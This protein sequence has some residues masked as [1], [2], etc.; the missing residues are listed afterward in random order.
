MRSSLIAAAVAFLF[1]PNW[2]AAE[3]AGASANGFTVRLTLNIQASPDDFYRKFVRNLG[4]CWDADHT[5]S[6]RA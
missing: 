2:A 6:R 4:D 1:G 5:F 3:I